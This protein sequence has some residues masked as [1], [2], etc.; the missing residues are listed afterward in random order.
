MRVLVFFPTYN[1]AQNVESLI[2][3]IRVHLPDADLLVV[4]DASP[5]GTGRL[6]DEVAARVPGMTVLHRPAKLGLGSAHRLAMCHARDQAYDALIV[7][8]AD[9]SHAPR[10]L[11]RFLEL[12][13]THDFVI[14]SRF[15][16][17]GRCDYGPARQLLSRTANVLAR[18]AIGAPLR[19]NTTSYRAYRGSLLRRMRL[20]DLRAEGYSFPIETLAH[21]YEVTDHIAEFPIHFEERAAGASKI[22]K[23]EI[24]RGGAMVLRLAFRRLLD[25]RSARLRRWLAWIIGA[26][27]FI[28]LAT[29]NGAGYRYGASD[30]AFYVPAVLEASERGMFPRDSALLDAQAGLTVVDDVLGGLVAATGIS[31]PALSLAG[32]LL[33]L[34]LIWGGALRIGSRLY[35]TPLATGALATALTLRHQIPLTSTN[36]LEPYFHPRMLA[37]GLGVLAVAALVRRRDTATVV[38]VAATALVHP[39]TALWFAIL[40]GT[41]LCVL[42]ARWRRAALVGALPAAALAAWMLTAGPMAGRLD[43]MDATWLRALAVRP[44]L[45]AQTW[46][47]WAWAANLA[48]LALAWGSHHVRRAQGQASEAERGLV[49]GATMLVVVFLITLPAVAADIIIAVQLQIA[50]VF[51]LVDLVLA[52]VVVGALVDAP[53]QGQGARL[54]RRA[55]AAAALLLA[56]TAGR[57]AYIMLVERPERPL[58]AVTLGDTPWTDAMDWLDTEAPGAHVLAAPDHAARY[59]ASIRVDPGEDVFLDADNDGA[60]AIY[61]RDVAARF[62][63]RTAR[64][65]SFPSLTAGD[66]RA[67]AADYGLTHLV[68][69]ARLPLPLAYENARFRIYSLTP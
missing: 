1:E 63:E 16:E 53:S 69:E 42:D 62:V 47:A 5:D 56:L 39:T 59:G 40:I 36:S 29:A 4:D 48:L 37:F 6:L 54:P 64:L 24:V 61:S 9:F 58:F 25:K 17:G 34:L 30:Q 66:V 15:V 3:E 11:P 19:E 2:A 22:S 51:W 8:D 50:R 38:L 57:G 12:L 55:V 44:Q 32:Y 28:V 67:L 35:G 14:G 23:G 52:I 18:A 43:T 7:M 41:A 33:S 49:W 20:E 60:I 27:L 31:V 10:Y 45:F 26:A 65:E 68:T 13:E 46:P 21:V